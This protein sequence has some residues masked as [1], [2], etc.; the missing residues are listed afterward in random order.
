MTKQELGTKRL[1]AHC[2]A[3]F[4]DLHHSPIT[5]PKCGTVFE[6]A[7]VSSRFGSGPAR[8][9]AREGEV[10]MPENNEVKYSSL[11]DPEAAEEQGDTVEPDDTSLNESPALR[12]PPKK[13]PPASSPS[14]YPLGNPHVLTAC[15]MTDA[16][17]PETLPKNRWPA[18]TS[19]LGV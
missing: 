2:G 11:E 16:K 4:Y 6:I 19:S 17:A 7:P 12:S 1:C 9:P 14:T 10:E 15:S 8:A 18:L 5:C 3:R 13:A